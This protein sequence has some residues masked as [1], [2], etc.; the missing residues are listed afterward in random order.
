[1]TD[2]VTTKP[3]TAADVEAWEVH[4]PPQE[5]VNGKWTG[6]PKMAGQEHNLI[7]TQLLVALFAFA[8]ERGLG[9]VYTDGL[10]YV[11]DGE[12][13]NIVKMRIPD[14]S[15]VVKERVSDPDE[16]GYYYL[17][18]D[19]AVEIISPTEAKKETAEKI[20]D[21]LRFGTQQVWVIDPDTKQ[22][23]VYTSDGNTQVYSDELSGGDVL[24]GFELPLT[25]LFK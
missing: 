3:I 6:I 12:P 5:I 11:L 19:L 1:M 10:N 23:T 16:K 17:A 18:P 8:N 9:Q 14:L 2:K 15:F 22:V 25:Q 7:G 24:P 13:G 21:Y 4:N 20:A